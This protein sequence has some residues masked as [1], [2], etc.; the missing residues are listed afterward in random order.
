MCAQ[1]T[2][3]KYFEASRDVQAIKVN[4]D[5]R[6]MSITNK[7]VSDNADSKD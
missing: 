4:L 7:D 3:K 2:E 1:C 5:T 6:F